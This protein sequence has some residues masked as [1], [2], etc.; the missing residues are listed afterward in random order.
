MGSKRSAERMASLED[1]LRKGMSD[2]GITPKSQEEIILGIRSF[3]LYGFPESHAASFALLVYASSYLKAHHPAAFFA[4]L[5]NNWPMGFYHPATVVKD[6]QRHGVE[7]LPIDVTRSGWDCTIEDGRLRLGLR[8]VQGFREA[9]GKRI[10][11][12]R[13]MAP[14]ATVADLARRCEL[15]RAELDRL[16]HAGALAGFGFTRREALWQ[17]A[18]VE[19]DPRSLFAGTSPPT[20]DSPLPDMT[21]IEETLADYAGTG[22]TPGPHV[23]QHL[24]PEL[25]RRGVVSNADLRGVE[26]GR[27]IRIAGHVIVRQRPGTAKGFLFLTLED[28]TGTSNAIVT[29]HMFERHRL[30]LQTA[31][32][33]MV[34]GEIQNVDGVIH[35]R[36]RRFE[37]LAVPGTT[38]RSH[39]FH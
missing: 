16:A 10:E 34:E 14:F 8:Y 27:R 23:L 32:I 29:P 37:A 33:L 31:A 1:R 15:R 26:N 39:D 7:V 19:T 17:V 13:R 28:E 30:L 9:A 20:A 36:G 4:A 11:A 22:L 38:P 12:E 21:A 18:A 3:A 35:V 2:R 5:L 6:A 24:R 25:D